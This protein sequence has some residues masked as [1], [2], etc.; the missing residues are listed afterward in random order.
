MDP[1]NLCLSPL[2]SCMQSFV[3]RQDI[4]YVFRTKEKLHDLENVMKHLMATKETVRR[5]L[6]DP[7]HNGKLLDNQHQVKDW[8]RDVGEKEDKVERLLDEYGKGNCVPAGSCSL[9]C[10]SRYKIGR[11]A[12]KLKEEITQL[13]IKQPEIKFTNIPPPKSVPESSKI[14]GEKILSNL[15]IACSYLAEETNDIIGIWGMGGVGKTTLLKKINQL[16]LDNANMGFDHVLFIQA[17]QNTQLEELRNE[18]AKELHL[19]PDAVQKDIFNALKTKNIVLLLDNIWEPVDLVGLGIINPYRDDDDITKSNK[20]KVIFTTRLEDVRDQMRASKIIKVECLEPDEAWAL[21]KHNA[22]L[23][24][25]ESDERINEIAKQVMNM[26]G[27]LPLALQTLG[28]AMSKRKTVQDWE[29]ILDSIKNSGTEVLQGVQGSFLPIL[30][31]SYDNLPRNIQEC[32]LWAS[33]LGWLSKDDLIECWICLGLIGNF[34]NLQQ[35][36]GTAK[37]IFNILEEAGLLYSSDNGCVSSHDVIYEMALWIASDLGMNM[38]KWI[39]EEYDGLAEIPTENRENWRMADRVIISGIKLVPILS[40]QCD[41]LLCLMILNSSYLKNIPRGFFGQMPNLIYLDLS[42]SAIKKLPEDIKCLVN[43]QYLNISSTCISSLPKE[44]V[45]LSKLQYLM[46]GYLR[47][48]R[49]VKNGLLSRLHKLQIIDLYPYGW[50][51]LEELKMSK[52]HNNIKAIGMRVVSQEVL[53]ELSCL[54]TT[55]LHIELENLEEL[56]MNG[57]GSYLNY[58]TIT[59]NEKLQKISWTDISP[60]EHFHAL[61]A[62][63]ISEC[64]LASFAWVLHLPSLALLNVQHCAEVKELFY[65]EKREIHQVSERPMFP[66]LQYLFLVYLP[67]LVSISNFAVE[68]P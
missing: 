2:C 55:Q 68:F 66:A 54:P 62:L 26:S 1:V 57:N 20:Y 11:N 29:F 37:Y 31:L 53:R 52:K 16:L 35:A 47:W 5:K 44:L 10:F 13:T 32:F 36:Y 63:F 51:E 27:G 33:I 17:S 43:L 8:L 22:N 67:K 41:D 39:V 23:A 60:P 28:K 15:N 58:L 3:T 49:K 24:V 61:K 45:Y 12:F 18:I 6:D 14:V 30:K 56:V 25:I 38:N 34:D 64:N 65:V 48:L 9:N 7:Q 46:C 40:L 59:N 19:A 21:F 50:V 42:K 4:S